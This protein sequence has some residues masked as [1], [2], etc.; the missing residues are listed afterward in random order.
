VT[1]LAVKR[2]GESI[3]NPVGAT[4][5]VTGDILFVVGPHDWNPL[6]VT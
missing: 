1:I 3:G 2:G 5:L 4:E 6:T